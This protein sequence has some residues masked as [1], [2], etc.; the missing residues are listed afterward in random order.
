MTIIKARRTSQTRSLKVS[1]KVSLESIKRCCAVLSLRTLDKPT[2]RLKWVIKHEGKYSTKSSR[3]RGI[4]LGLAEK[5]EGQELMYRLYLMGCKFRQNRTGARSDEMYPE[6]SF[7]R[8]GP[9]F[10]EGRIV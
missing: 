8:P 10:E 3:K 1:V 5:A 6:E 4:P 9:R 7:E 2:N